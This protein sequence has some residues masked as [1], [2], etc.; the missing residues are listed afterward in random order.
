[1]PVLDVERGADELPWSRRL[2]L[3]LILGAATMCW[4]VPGVLVYWLAR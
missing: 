1:M 3:F 2:R 4:A